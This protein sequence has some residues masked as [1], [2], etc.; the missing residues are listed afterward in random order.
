MTWTLFFF[1][2]DSP[3]LLP[4]PALK[5]SLFAPLAS[6][7]GHLDGS[8]RIKIKLKVNDKHSSNE[9][10]RI[11][12]ALLADEPIPRAHVVMRSM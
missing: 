10:S 11:Q 9:N 12:K 4:T 3:L 5:R 6:I 8:E 7:E 2:L 1:A